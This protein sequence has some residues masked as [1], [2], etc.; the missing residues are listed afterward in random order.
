[1]EINDDTSLRLSF[2]HPGIYTQT[3][4]YGASD[5]EENSWN[6]LMTDPVLTIIMKNMEK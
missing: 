4:L 1:M 5:T 6:G 3:E 2:L